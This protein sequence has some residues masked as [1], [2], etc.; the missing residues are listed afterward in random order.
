L[1]PTP[2]TATVLKSA[3]RT[4]EDHLWAEISIICEERASTELASLSSGSFWEG[5]V[6]SVEKGVQ[7]ISR[8]QSQHAEGVWKKDV[9]GSL[10]DL[11]SVSVIEGYVSRLWFRFLLRING[12][13]TW[14]GN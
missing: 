10:E 13:W 5:G 9:L 3:G 4:W 12:Y 2:Q 1:A 11:K 7:D 8:P 6:D 14:I